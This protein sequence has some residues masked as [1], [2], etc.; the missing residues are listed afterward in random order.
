[1]TPE[2]LADAT[3]GDPLI[4]WAA[5]RMR[6]GVRAWI[7]PE[8]VAV[9]CPDLSCR[10]RMAVWGSP[11]AVID[12]LREA[13]P[14]AG[15]TFRPIGDEAL[16]AELATAVEPLTMVGR[17]AWM[18]VATPVPATGAGDPHWLAETELDEATELI[19][20][21]FPDSFARPRGSGV[22]RWAGIRDG[23]GTLLA[24]A[25]DA[26]SV[27]EVGFL[28]GVAVRAEARG[29][30]LASSVC[31]FVTNEQLAGSAG[32]VALLADYWNEAAVATY[33]RLG[34]S[35]RPLG[36]AHWR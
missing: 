19:D 20:L 7:R 36:A 13:L 31:S 23:D 26:W 24:V 1:V 9:A 3:G 12:L 8:A 27:P 17:F 25:A 5:Q 34:F 4:R 33:R 15:P 21:A 32:R 30:G 28:A 10:D 22:H 16:I 35:V 2:D 14:E 6:P 18:E 11:G 29:R